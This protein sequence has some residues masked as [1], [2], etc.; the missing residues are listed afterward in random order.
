ML[1]IIHHVGIVVVDI[2]RA[3]RDY[4]QRLGYRIDGPVVHDPIQTA[5]VQFLSASDGTTKLEL[6]TPDGPGSKLVNALKKGGGLNHL[7]FATSTIEDDCNA[8]SEKGLFVLQ[9]PVVAAAF[10]GRRIAWLMGR[11]GIPVE[12]IEVP[13]DGSESP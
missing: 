9:R 2:E 10:E 13:A 12:L 11:D 6:V 3:A 4:S 5:L 8:L 7:A 1:G